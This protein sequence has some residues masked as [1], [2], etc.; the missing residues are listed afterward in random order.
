MPDVSAVSDKQL[1][2]LTDLAQKAGLSEAEACGRV[3]ATRFD[4][5][6]GGREG[7]ASRLITQ[8]KGEARSKGRPPRANGA[9]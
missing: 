9:S 6:T 3:G 1:R 8:L 2:F 5:L 4:E 7:T